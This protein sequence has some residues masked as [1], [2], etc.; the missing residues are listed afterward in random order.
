MDP[1]EEAEKRTAWQPPFC[2]HD[3]EK[4]KLDCPACGAESSVC[5]REHEL[6][7][8]ADEYEAF[9]EE[10]H[11]MLRTSACVDISFCEAEIVNVDDDEEPVTGG[12]SR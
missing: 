1:A 10:C 4:Y 7:L 3:A 11:A 6:Y 9:C 12:A 8:D 5:V 2:A